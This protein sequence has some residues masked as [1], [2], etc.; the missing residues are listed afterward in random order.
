M[1]W[2]I[3]LLIVAPAAYFYAAGSGWLIDY[4]I[5]VTVLNRGIRRLVDWMGG[6]FNVFSPISLTPLVIA[7]FVFLVVLKNR[8]ALPGYLQHIIRFFAAALGIGFLVGLVQNQLAAVYALAE[9]V[10]PLSIMGCA[11]IAKGNE[12]ILD[13]WIKSVGWA[14]V[15][16][17]LYGWYQYYTIPPWDAFWVKAVGFEGYLGKLRPTEMTVFSTMS[18]RGVLAGFLA[19]AVIPMMISGRWRNAGGWAS[20]ALIIA[21]ILLTY[22]RTAIII[23]ALAT[24]M[25]P[26]LNRGRHSF[27]IILML[28]VA[29]FAGSYILKGT[30]SSGK[31]GERMQTIG[32]I[33]EDGSFK[34]RIQIASYG[35]GALLRNPLG[36]G[37]GS[38][39]LAGRVNT[40]GMEA[41][42]AIGDNGYF[43]VLL[44]FGIL[45]GG[46]FFYAFYLIWKQV[47][48]FEKRGIR[49]ETLMVFKALFVTGAVAL[50]AGNWLAGPGS[51]VFCI[52]A[53]F[54]VYP[55]PAM[56][57]IARAVAA[58][59]LRDNPGGRML[60]QNS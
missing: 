6:S 34:G 5:W 43:E 15:A 33:T 10:A 45:G 21:T 35:A 9:Y 12:R 8:R 25:F 16:V 11:A 39:G 41:G 7:G 58:K 23:I 22:V 1:D 49:S 57:R 32:S 51:V 50:F 4:L 40:G 38:T 20:V 37:L 36:M 48:I 17:S 56:D 13:R 60:G 55:K 14:A 28:C 31:V 59:R 53:G 42:G 54:A 44:S 29:A 30:P 2:L 24:I 47:R 18:E 46:C 26:V 19:F 52:F 27:Q 3:A